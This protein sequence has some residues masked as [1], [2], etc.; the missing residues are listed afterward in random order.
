[1]SIFK[2][3]ILM[4]IGGIGRFGNAFLTGKQLNACPCILSIS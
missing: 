2:N 1:M 3:K 4:I